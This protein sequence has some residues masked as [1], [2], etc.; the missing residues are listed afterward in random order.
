MMEIFDYMQGIPFEG[1]PQIAEAVD[2][3]RE[4]ML[5]ADMALLRET[6]LALEL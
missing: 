1:I 3:K 2:A 5:S 4:E 6:G